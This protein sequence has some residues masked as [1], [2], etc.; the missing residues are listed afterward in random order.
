MLLKRN[1]GHCAQRNHS[2][3]KTMTQRH[4]ARRHS[5]ER[6]V[7]SKARPTARRLRRPVLSDG[8]DGEDSLAGSSAAG[9]PCTAPRVWL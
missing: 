1:P 9:F 8:S 4:N 5:K 2:D 7:Q 6:M 3:Q